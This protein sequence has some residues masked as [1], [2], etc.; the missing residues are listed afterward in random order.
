VRLAEA[1]RR[2]RA[3][4]VGAVTILM[5]GQLSVGAA[6]GA[7]FRLLELG[8]LRVKWGAPELGRG[9]EVT[10]GF[11]AAPQAFPDAINCRELAPVER[12]AGGWDRERMA[13]VAADAFALWGAA[14]GIDFRPA[15][16]GETPDIL[17]GAQGRPTAIAFANVWPDRSRAVAGVAP[18][19]RATI[20]LNPK[21]VWVAD[22]AGAGQADLGTVLAHEIG[23]AIGLDHPGPTGALMGYR[24]QGDID[25]LMPGDAAGAVL[26]YGPKRN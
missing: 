12:L 19:A 13:R 6:L 22:A 17:I 9:A 8:G 21:F 2:L 26:L 16:P 1:G 23:H 25:S 10:Y 4:T 11:V 7:D 24:D 18:L 5:C 14:A 15:E 3:L 20:C